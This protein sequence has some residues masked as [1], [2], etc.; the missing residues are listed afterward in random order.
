MRDVLAITKALGDENRIRILLL[1]GGQELCVCQILE[2]FDLAPSTVSRHLSILYTAGLIDS[3]KEGRW[4]YYRLAG[5]GAPDNVQK[6]LAWIIAST[7][8]DP[9][10]TADR[11]RLNKIMQLEPEELCRLQAAR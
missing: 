1:L 6:A 7:Q 8:D 5:K 10:V 2:V 9:Q 3:R 11:K 4:V